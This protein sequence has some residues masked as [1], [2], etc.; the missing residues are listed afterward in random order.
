M[1]RVKAAVAI[2]IALLF[3]GCTDFPRDPANSLDKIRA[4]G[5]IRVGTEQDLPPEAR[6]LVEQVETAAGAKAELRRGALEPL[7]DKLET[8]EIDL[9]VA[10]FTKKTPWATMSALSPP[11]RTEGQGEQTVEWRAAMRSGENRWIMLV[12]TSA[13]KVARPKAAP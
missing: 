6:T 2:A 3:S 7:L 8:G 12:E 4:S 11:V 9:V 13:R 10:P 5:T 1:S